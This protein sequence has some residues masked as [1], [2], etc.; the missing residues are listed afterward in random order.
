MR[1]PALSPGFVARFVYV[2]L[3]PYILSRDNP[4]VRSMRR[5]TPAVLLSVTLALALAFS[6]LAWARAGS[7]GSM[8]S[9]GSRTFSAPPTTSTSPFAAQPMQRSFS[10]APPSYPAPSYASPSYASP[11]Y[12]YGS[13]RS[14]FSSG[15]LGGLLGAG[16]GGML[17]G[18]GLFHGLHGGGSF[19][20]LLIQLALLYFAGRWLYRRFFAG[21]SQGVGV[22]GARPFFAGLGGANRFAGLGGSGGLGGVGGPRPRAA[23]ALN[24]SRQ[25]FDAFG[26]LLQE[27]QAA[28]SHADLA[29]LQRVATP[30]MVSYFGEQLAEQASRGVRNTVSD[31]RLEKGDL[32]EAWSEGSREYATVAMRFSSIDV[33][34]DRSGRVVDGSEGE[35]VTATELW[36]FLRARGGQW[37]LSAIQ[38]AG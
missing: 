26:Q 3:A 12:G 31:V 9:R 19:L 4:R 11:G 25:D 38:Q 30:E 7:G 18:G 33:T 20:G 16:I 15:L 13:R 37:V 21:A 23:P 36:T 8:G 24:L 28:W 27:M 35:R 6:P 10:A 29:R 14:A 5:L 17:F 1:R 34:R 22:G 2:R 32:S